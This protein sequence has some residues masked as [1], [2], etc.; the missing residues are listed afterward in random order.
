ML[1][2]TGT[3]TLFTLYNPWP[4]PCTPRRGETC[5]SASRA[6]RQRRQRRRGRP[7]RR[8]APKPCRL[9]ALG[10][11]VHHRERSGKPSCSSTRVVTPGWMLSG[12]APPRSS[13]GARASGSP[14]RSERA[15][16]APRSSLRRAWLIGDGRGRRCRPR[17]P[18]ASGAACLGRRSENFWGGGRPS[19]CSN[20]MYLT[21]SWST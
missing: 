5:H 2:S 11:L 10:S 21:L 7:R 15:C 19:T 8:G 16:G 18:A 14:R 3:G 1:S 17:G 12:R 4:P 13:G 20:G 9:L 6:G